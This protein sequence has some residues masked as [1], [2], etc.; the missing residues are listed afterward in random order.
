[1]RADLA[2]AGFTDAETGCILGAR[3]VSGHPGGASVGVIV[4]TRDGGKTFRT[5]PT[6][7]LGALAGGRVRG[8]RGIVFGRSNWFSP[9]GAWL[10]VLGGR[11]WTPVKSK[12]RGSIFGGAFLDNWDACLVGPDNRILLLRG[13]SAAPQAEISSDAA[14][15][16]VTYAGKN[17]CWAVGEDGS[18]Y[19]INPRAKNWRQGRLTLPADAIRLADLEAVVVS[20][21]TVTLAGG[22]TGRCFVAADDRLTF[23]PVAAPGPGPVHALHSASDGALL[24][25]GDG[26]RIWRSATA[27]S[28]PTGGAGL[29]WQLVR[30]PRLVDVLFIAA[31]GDVTLLPAVAAH[32]AAGADVA[33]VWGAVPRLAAPAGLTI[34]G[35]VHLRASASDAGA[36]GSTALSDFISIVGT[37]GIDGLDVEG[38]LERYEKSLDIPPRPELLR[39]LA[40]AIRLYRPKVVARGPETDG[41]FGLRAENHLLSRLAGEAVR[42][43]AD[44]K[45]LPD[46]A[47]VGLPAWRVEREYIGFDDNERFTPPWAKP[48]AA[49]KVN[50]A[51]VLDG[52]RYV[53]GRSTSLSMAARRAAIMLPWA[54]RSGRVA[55]RTMY[56]CSLVIPRGVLFIDAKLPIRTAPVGEAIAS[57]M[58]LR[59]PAM[60]RLGLSSAID[61][62]VRA[63]QA[64]PNDPLPVDYLELLLGRMLE[65]GDLQGAAAVLRT[66]VA[67]GGSHPH[68][69]RLSLAALAMTASSEWARQI[70]LFRPAGADAPPDVKVDFAAVIRRMETWPMAAWTMDEPGLALLARAQAAPANNP[71]AASA[72]YRRIITRSTDPTWRS[73]AQAE[74]VE[75]GEAD[76]ATLGVGIAATKVAGGVPRVDGRLNEP[77][78]S[79]VFP[80][81]LKPAPDAP[82][83]DVPVIARVG[84]LPGHLAV[85]VH[86]GREEGAPPPP[87]ELTLAIDA[88]R[89]A[90]TQ[91]VLQCDSTGRQSRKLQTRLAPSAKLSPGLLAL[92]AR[93]GKDGWTIEMAMPYATLARPDAPPRMMRAQLIVK[94]GSS[95]EKRHTLYLIPQADDRLLPH[96]YGLLAVPRPGDVGPLGQ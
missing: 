78:W 73:Y 68:A 36:G 11:T 79:K 52:R 55:E 86:I 28:Q 20:G 38:V 30:G 48:V 35:D 4:V 7:G 62:I 8:A 54:D 67:R 66:F 26:G 41:V 5:L 91:V 51:V 12:S 65:T 61:P 85:A 50:V 45:A 76:A 77:F 23:A 57:G 84:A 46:L 83:G 27:T 90:W 3:S 69:E 31:P 19:R 16:A 75:L 81:A 94:V 1:V 80:A 87:W 56:Q 70:K 21:K 25:G 32:A 95:E 44:G 39:H 82:A 88:D 13:L 6:P 15:T 74:L 96:R 10:T 14:L 18:V 71:R 59:L 22:L 63:A 47:K 42:L 72:T 2:A 37:Y 58:V 24:A 64:H 40:A 9:G 92:Q 93:R 53:R 17:I 29:G 49:P 89:D 43:A 60:Q 33:I 34:R